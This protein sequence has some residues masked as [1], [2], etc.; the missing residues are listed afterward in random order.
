MKYNYLV[1]GLRKDTIPNA[2]KDW[3]PDTTWSAAVAL[4]VGFRLANCIPHFNFSHSLHD[5]PNIYAKLN[6]LPL[7]LRTCAIY[8]DHRGVCMP[9]R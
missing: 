1:R 4:A 5:K 8:A 3:L 2:V 9:I 6:R 7:L